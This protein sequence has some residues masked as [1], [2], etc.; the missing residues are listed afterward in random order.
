MDLDRI[1]V[2]IR[3]RTLWEAVDLGFI[4]ARKW[5]WKLFR[6]SLISSVIIFG[7]LLPIAFLL[8]GS[9]AKWLLL[10]FWL[11][12]PM[13]EPLILD[14][15]SYAVFGQQNSVKNSAGHL[16]S[17]LN[18]KRAVA[19]FWNRFN[20]YRCF[21]L[22]VIQLEKMTGKSKKERIKLLTNGSGVPILL[23]IG[24]FLAEL[25]LALSLMTVVFWFLPENLRWVD[26]G[27]FIFTPDGW[28]LSVG[29]CISAT[30]LAPFTVTAGFM[31]YLSRR[32]ELEAWDLEIG[33]K[34][35]RKRHKLLLTTKAARTSL[36]SMILLV[37]LAA[38]PPAGF[39]EMVDPNASQETIQKVLQNKEFGEEVTRYH[40]V[41]KIE[42]PKEVDLS[43]AERL[44]QLLED[45]AKQLKSIAAFLAVHGEI[46]LW[47]LLV[48]GAGFLLLKYTGLRRWLYHRSLTNNSRTVPKQMFGLD[49]SPDSLPEDIPGMCRQLLEAGRQREALSLLYRGTLSTFINRFQ[50][51]IEP[52]Y[53]EN[54]CCTVVQ[55]YRPE[56]ESCFFNSL[57]S[58]WIYLAYGHQDPEAKKCFSLVE[59]YQMLFE[60]SL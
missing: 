38:V 29:Y 52:S 40:W 7:S 56:N 23:L 21:S 1:T 24:C 27:D 14:W 53:T 16:Y 9:A 10:L 18:F 50:L 22:S 59:N 55:R 8:P 47:A 12:K 42:E 17:Y 3:P 26:L 33:F 34:R 44:F 43:W 51:Q 19:L 5:Y 57:T 32:V 15:L 49:L 2:N 20:M 37:M 41:P 48:L 35:I 13:N 60:E 31:I 6:L 39:A 58:L 28:I 4:L 36:I 54:E 45:A 25:A 46:L 11:C 30:F